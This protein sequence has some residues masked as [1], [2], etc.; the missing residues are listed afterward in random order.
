ML[1]KKKRR[2][3]SFNSKSWIFRPNIPFLKVNKMSGYRSSVFHKFGLFSLCCLSLMACAS[4][5]ALAQDKAASNPVAPV[6]AGGS[7]G[8]IVTEASENPDD[9]DLKSLA[10]AKKEEKAE[11][12]SDSVPAFDTGGYDFEDSDTPIISEAPP[13][14]EKKGSD[15]VSPEDV[16]GEDAF[17]DSEAIGVPKGRM[18]REGPAPVNPSENPA[19][20]LVIVEEVKPAGDKDTQ[21]Q[22]AQR[23]VDLGRYDSA[24]RIYEGLYTKNPKDSR[25][26][27]GKAVALQ[28]LDRFDEAM[29]TYEALLKLEP[30][31]TDIAVNMLGLLGRRYPAVA[32]R[33]LKELQKDNQQNIGVIS[34]IAVVSA[35]LGDIDTAMEYLG[36]AMGMQPEN[37]GHVYNA[38]VIMDRAGKTKE[39][40]QYY[41]K[42]LEVD[43]VYG[44]S[45]SIPRDAIYE[46]LASIR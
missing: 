12:K 36:M 21:L 5:I 42:A 15:S 31:N 4:S 7:G 41:E 19:S 33:R 18:G 30:K 23:A 46:R 10:E 32:L 17:F 26:L 22:A 27:L 29:Q 25:V 2:D 11:R 39:A 44:G 43:S 20:K 24:L 8:V 34:Q 13:K 35:N 3:I 38:A 14:K 28:K 40:V 1:R 9:A 37:A 16:I 6:P 45:R